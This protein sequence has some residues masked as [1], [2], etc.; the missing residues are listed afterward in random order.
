[1]FNDRYFEILGLDPSDRYKAYTL[2]D[3]VYADDLEIILERNM[4]L[5]NKNQPYPYSISYRI[6]KKNGGLCHITEYINQ[7]IIK[8]ITYIQ[9]FIQD[10]TAVIEMEKDRRKLPMK[11]LIW[12]ENC[13]Y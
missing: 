1:M 5:I 12:G 11:P 13:R 8:G 3:I 6:V 9:S 2:L 7:F 10:V 4:A